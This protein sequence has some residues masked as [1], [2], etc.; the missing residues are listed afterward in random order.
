MF[1]LSGYLRL[2][3]SSNY[4]TKV[5]PKNKMSNRT[6]YIFPSTGKGL[7]VK[8]GAGFYEET[9]NA[10]QMNHIGLSLPHF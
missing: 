1:S 9:R 7:S 10:Q 3:C 5:D 4:I 6:K 2:D 8:N